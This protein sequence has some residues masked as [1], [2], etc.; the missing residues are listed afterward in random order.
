MSIIFENYKQL[1]KLEDLTVIKKTNLVDKKVTKKCG[2][3][4]KNREI[5]L[6]VHHV[7]SSIGTIFVGLN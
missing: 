4:M 7:N 5:L 2:D 3:I 1:K 6:F